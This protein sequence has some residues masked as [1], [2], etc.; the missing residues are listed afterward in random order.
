MTH[1][2]KILYQKDGNTSQGL[3]HIANTTPLLLG[4]IE[5]Q[6]S[7]LHFKHSD[8]EKNTQQP[9][10]LKKPNKTRSKLG[11][12]FMKPEVSKFLQQRPIPYHPITPE[13]YERFVE[14]LLYSTMKK[15]SSMMKTWQ[16]ASLVILSA[17]KWFWPH[18]TSTCWC[19]WVWY[20]CTNELY[21]SD[22]VNDEN[23]LI[24]FANE[25]CPANIISHK[26][27]LCYLPC[28]C[29]VFSACFFWNSFWWFFCFFS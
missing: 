25:H 19:F 23:Q 6:T 7:S 12:R 2:Q 11:P 17:H 1:Q 22:Q 15:S 21:A 8:K 10:G 26:V 24:I 18:W 14:K 28:N 9:K 16:P 13:E 20:R 27:L 4:R 3:Q 29:N 5:K